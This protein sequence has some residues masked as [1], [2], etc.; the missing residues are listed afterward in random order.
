[1]RRWAFWL[2]CA[3]MAV[4]V[5]LAYRSAV[6]S[7]RSGEATPAYSTRRHDPYGTAALFTLLAERGVEVR[8]VESATLRE[9]DQGVLVQVLK[10]D[11]NDWWD[12]RR[13]LQ[14][15]QLADW[16]GR[17]NTVVQLSR[18][19][20]ELMQHFKIGAGKQPQDE[21]IKKIQ[22]AEAKG[23]APEALPGTAHWARLIKIEDYGRSGRMRSAQPELYLHE[24]MTLAERVEDRNWTVLARARTAGEAI[25]AAEYK[26]GQGKLVVVGA[27]T[28]A[29]NGGIIESNNLDFM[30]NVVGKGPVLVDE[31]SLGIGQEATLIGFLLEA[32]LLPILIQAAFVAGLYI[33][34]TSE[35]RSE[36]D[37]NSKV[38]R[39]RAGAEQI[40]TLGFLYGRSLGIDVTYERVHAEVQHRL[41]EAMRCKPG[42]LIQ[43]VVALRTDW[44]MRVEKLLEALSTVKPT[45][46]VMCLTCGYDLRGNVTGRCPECGTIV[47]VEMRRKIGE[48]GTEKTPPAK[49]AFRGEAVLAQ[50][51]RESHELMMEIR[52]DSRGRR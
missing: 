27:P 13:H 11:A 40:V 50:A 7:S 26:V 48:A 4:G 8:T 33:W 30:L 39:N 44:R 15:K 25:V 5:L 35:P 10:G 41:C 1:M 23:D 32:G 14:T 9:S 45:G 12:R 43:R 52:R 17:G 18:K 6:F 19:Q 36:E 20:T 51:L 38:A 16:I 28:P 3:A 24:P 22:E 47:S 2:A 49:R 46:E 31:W 21:E 42:E 34:S 37:D 29:L